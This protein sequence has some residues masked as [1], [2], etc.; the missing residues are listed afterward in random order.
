MGLR[1]HG[2]NL[3]GSQAAQLVFERCH[4]PGEISNT[5]FYAVCFRKCDKRQNENRD[6]KTDYKKT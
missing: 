3:L 4:S 6:D 1:L 2:R 5:A